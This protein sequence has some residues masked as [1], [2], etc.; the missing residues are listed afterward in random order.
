MLFAAAMIA[1]SMLALLNRAF[2]ANNDTKTPLYVGTFSIALNFVFCNIFLYATDLGPAGMALAYSIQ[3][4]VN[5]VVMMYIISKKMDGMQWRKLLIYA[6]KLLSAAAIM[7][8]VL[9]FTNKFIPINFTQT[10]SLDSKLFEILTLG[11]EIVLGALIYF[12]FTMLLKVNEAVAFK[13]NLFGKLNRILKK[14]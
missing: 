7:G 6:G 2:Y 11:I 13:N 9:F 4:V 8:I 3:S 10:F 14:A 5:M 12:G 1:Q